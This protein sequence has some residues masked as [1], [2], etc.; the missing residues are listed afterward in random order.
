MNKLKSIRAGVVG[1]AVGV[2]F[3]LITDSILQN[4]E[5]IP[6]DNLWVGT[7]IILLIIFYRTVYNVLGAYITAKLAPQNPMKHAL[8][9]GVLGTIVSIIGVIICLKLHLGPLWYT[10]VLAVLAMPSAWLGG[11]LAS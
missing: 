7:N 5:I 6:K 9:V 11:K 1:I 8:V 4:I 2:A 3:S 10:V